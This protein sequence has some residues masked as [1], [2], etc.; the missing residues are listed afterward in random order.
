MAGQA[1]NRL[2]HAVH[3]R[4][5]HDVDHRMLVDWVAMPVLQRQQDHFSEV[6]LGQLYLAVENREQMLA[7]ELLRIR[8]WPM[9]LKAQ[10]VRAGSA[11][12]VCVVSTM[13]LVAG[14]ATLHECGLVQNCFLHLLGLIAMAGEAS[15]HWIR[16]QESRRLSGMRVMA[17]D[18]IALRAR[19][20]YLRRFNLLG[21]LVVA[22]Y[23]ERARV[24]V[25]QYNFSVLRRLVA[26]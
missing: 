5:I 24:V 9:A 20:L 17:R 25:G 10:L 8:V 4:R 13:R 11:Q 7:L 2:D 16:L 12:Q 22:R 15:L 14:C 23:T 3:V 6:V 19:M 1:I 18:A 21:L 26:A